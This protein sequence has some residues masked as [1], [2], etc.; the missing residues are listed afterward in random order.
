MCTTCCV[1]GLAAM[2]VATKVSPTT[3]ERRPETAL[4]NVTSTGA[5]WSRG[6]ATMTGYTLLL[7]DSYDPSADTYVMG[8]LII[9]TSRLSQLADAVSHLA[10]EL[11]GDDTTEL[12]HTEEPELVE[13][14]RARGNTIGTSRWKMS[15][16]PTAIGGITFVASIILDPTADPDGGA[17]DPVSWSFQRSV[18]HFMNFLTDAGTD[19]PP[20]SHGITVDRFPRSTSQSSTRRTGATTESPG[21]ELPPRSSESNRGGRRASM[22]DGRAEVRFRSW[23]SNWEG[24]RDGSQIAEQVPSRRQGRN[25]QPKPQDWFRAG[26]LATASRSAARPWVARTRGERIDE[27]FVP[28]HMDVRINADGQ[29]VLW[30]NPGT[31]RSYE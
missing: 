11:T 9:E 7:D 2:P 19:W 17:I 26:Y 12:K 30:M 27:A 4:A 18:T 29:R 20:G 31:R 13:R 23:P 10:W 8:G 25:V 16:L 1:L 14:L 5:K 28:V 15:G 24:N 3:R 22:G 6:T 21:W